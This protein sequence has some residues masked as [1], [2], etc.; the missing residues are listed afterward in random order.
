M[1]EAKDYEQGGFEGRD[2]EPDEKTAMGPARESDFFFQIVPGAV[3]S[4][5]S[6]LPSDTRMAT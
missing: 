6:P 4:S 1:K 3:L 5:A 2:S